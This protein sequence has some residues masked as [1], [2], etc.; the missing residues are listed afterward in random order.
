MTTRSLFCCSVV[1]LVLG[2][3]AGL[4]I[5]Q[6]PPANPHATPANPHATPATN[7]HAQAPASPHGTPAASPHQAHG[8]APMPASAPSAAAATAAV[9]TIVAGNGTSGFADGVGAAARF[10]KPIRLAPFGPDAIVVSDIYNHAIRIVSKDGRVR[11]ITGGPDRKGHADGPSAT[12]RILSPHG[13]AT[14]P[15][16]RIL[17]AEAEGHTLRA[18]APR[19]G[20]PGE[21]DVTTLA[22]TP[23]TKGN[24]DGPAPS[25]TFNSPH[26][27]LVGADGAVY[28]PDIGN[29]T[30]RRVKDGKVETVAGAAPDTMVYPMD[31]AWAADGRMV[32][33]DAGAN[34]LRTWTA[35]APLG[36]I[37]VAGGLATP[38]GVASGPDGALYVAD[39]K[40]QRVLKIDPA[41]AVTTV[42]GVAGEVGSDS[43]HLNRPAAVLV[44]AGWLWIADL[45]NHRITAV[46]VA[47]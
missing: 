43:R 16:G 13:V 31:I 28:T 3:A 24:A 15:D 46:P 23:E 12:A 34:R 35:G 44:H 5:A 30:I 14:T 18:I 38:H 22:G 45:D 2:S 6:T 21:Y 17:V 4:A 32:I 19:A 40:S 42:A 39:M 29:A 7:P 47:R 1:A 20:A 27:V 11:T 8:T 36:E 9:M 25:A 37:A 41:G 10:N 33:A 26:A